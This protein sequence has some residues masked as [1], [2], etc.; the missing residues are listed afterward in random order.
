MSNGLSG[1]RTNIMNAA[2]V[3]VSG[4]LALSAGRVVLGYTKVDPS[5]NF[6][7][8]VLTNGPWLQIRGGACNGYASE[9]VGEPTYRIKADLWFA[10]DEAVSY[11]MRAIEDLIDAVRENVFQVN[12]LMTWD[13][14]EFDSLSNPIFGHYAITMEIIGTF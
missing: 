14:P 13:D 2:P 5:E 10:F 1:L 7:Q 6:I 3:S 8:D 4:G 12:A 11:D 9:N